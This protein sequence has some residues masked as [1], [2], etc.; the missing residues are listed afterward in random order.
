MVMLDASRLS[1]W[2]MAIAS[3]KVLRFVEC[4]PGK[5]P[6]AISPGSD[7]AHSDLR[8]LSPAVA[9]PGSQYAPSRSGG[10]GRDKSLARRTIIA[11][12]RLAHH[13]PAWLCVGVVEAS[14]QYTGK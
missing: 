2:T 13:L 8:V 10:R 7:Q 12:P 1:L 14:A 11:T 3:T 5:G 6:K 4:C 9:S